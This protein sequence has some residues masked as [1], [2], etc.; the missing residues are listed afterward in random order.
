M[1]TNYRIIKDSF[2]HTPEYV[3][4]EEKKLVVLNKEDNVYGIY[5]VQYDDSGAI[6]YAIRD[7]YI[8][9]SNL[10]QLEAVLI[11]M[12]RAFTKPVL[13]WSEIKSDQIIID[14]NAKQSK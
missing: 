3:L 10:E 5:Q 2:H 6:K 12:L 14:N 1:Y 13:H 4:D 8:N 7:T 9:T 11:E